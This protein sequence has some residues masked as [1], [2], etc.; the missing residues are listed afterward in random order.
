M[1]VQW[2]WWFWWDQCL[3][4]RIVTY[5]NILYNE[6]CYVDATPSWIFEQLGLH[7][8]HR[9]CG[10]KNQP[11]WTRIYHHIS[12][13]FHMYDP[14]SVSVY[15]YIIHTPEYEQHIKTIYS[16]V[17][18]S[19]FLRIAPQM[20]FTRTCRFARRPRFL[21]SDFSPKNGQGGFCP[22]ELAITS[23]QGCFIWLHNQCMIGKVGLWV[24]QPTNSC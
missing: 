5:C 14:V 22:I 20:T 23:T 24:G 8:R 3:D 6:P 18:T 7:S 19:G 21:F 12:T 13:K 17:V 2:F 1:Y 9:S 15:I 10:N 11:C 16:E 4:K